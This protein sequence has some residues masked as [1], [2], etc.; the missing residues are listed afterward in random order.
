MHPCGSSLANTVQDLSP[1]YHRSSSIDMEF[2]VEAPDAW[3]ND[4][5]RSI[6]LDRRLT[7]GEVLKIFR[8]NIS[9]TIGQ[10]NAN[11]T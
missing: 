11:L 1:V 2:N 4:L 9:S 5:E 8:L 3:Y 6:Y 10:V 7:Q